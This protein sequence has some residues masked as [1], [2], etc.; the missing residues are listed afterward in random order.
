M[1]Y[2]ADDWTLLR[3]AILKRYLCACTSAWKDRSLTTAYI[4]VFSGANYCAD[5]VGDSSLLA[6]FPNLAHQPPKALLTHS[7][8]A[9]LTADPPFD[10]YM[11]IERNQHRCHVL[12]ALRHEFPQ[13]N[14]QIRRFDANRELRRIS[15]LNWRERR[16]V[17]FV[18]AYA[19][20]LDW[21]TTCDIS[22][23]NAVDVWLLFPVGIGAYQ[24]PT[25][26][27]PVPPYW[28]DRLKPLL[29]TDERLNSLEASQLPLNELLRMLARHMTDRLRDTFANVSSARV[30]RSSSGAPLYLLCF[31]SSLA[32][33]EGRIA[34]E[35][36]HHMLDSPAVH[37]V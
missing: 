24:P 9:A 26:A 27:V 2:P 32:G 1:F 14:I 8:R 29:Q 34:V 5:D 30:M 3:L 21:K 28:R 13:R 31:A 15:H 33:S 20:N 11:F 35:L 10:G 36:A 22:R 25:K 7:A 37:T 18:D 23:T 6:G 19:A 16:A 17:L 12:E 4:D